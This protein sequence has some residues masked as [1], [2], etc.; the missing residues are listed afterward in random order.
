MYKVLTID[1]ENAVRDSF[2]LALEDFEDIKVYEAENG[3]E[4]VNL[5]KEIQPNLV[6]LD[7]KMPI[8]NGAEALEQIRAIDP[9]V[10]VY[11]VTAFA[12][13]FFEDL[14]KLRSKGMQ[15]E[16]A[17]KPMSLKQIEQITT[18]ILGI[19]G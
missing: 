1:D 6:F 14:E 3:L 7:L 15:F 5:F 13:E 16:V 12:K 8:M 11:I 18:A 19:K 2:L 9:K 10:P 17:A 4:G